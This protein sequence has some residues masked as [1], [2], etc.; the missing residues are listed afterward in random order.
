[1]HSP[2]SRAI[3]DAFQRNE[4]TGELQTA[5]DELRTAMDAMPPPPAYL[6]ALLHAKHQLP[7]W[8]VRAPL[9]D[10]D[11]QQTLLAMQALSLAALAS[12]G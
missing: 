6:K 8:P 1:L 5:L 11:E 9:Q 7:L 12:S 3:F 10:F 2:Q 4:K